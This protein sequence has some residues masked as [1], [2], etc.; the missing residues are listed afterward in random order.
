[1]R[2]RLR[3]IPAA[4]ALAMALS[5]RAAAQDAASSTATQATAV[6]ST[7][8]SE[9]VVGPAQ[10]RDFSLQGTV[11]RR[12]ET[13]APA[14]ATSPSPPE[15][16]SSGPEP[17]A[18]APAPA[19]RVEPGRQ[20][21]A[22]ATGTDPVGRTDSSRS[23]AGALPA[24]DQ[25]LSFSPATLAPQSI[26]ASE[27]A[28]TEGSTTDA[29]GGL[30]SYW[31]W[32]LAFLTALGAGLWYL[33]RQR[34]AHHYAYAG[35]GADAVAFERSP[36]PKPPAPPRAEPFT[37]APAPVPNPAP[38]P[39]LR[40]PEERALS[41]TIVSTKLRAAPEAKPAVAPPPAPL[42]I[43]STRLRP[44]LDIEF[45]PLEAAFNDRQGVIQFDVTLFNSGSGPAREVLLEARLF[46]AGADQDDSIARYFANPTVEGD[47]IGVIEPLKRMT[48]RTSAMVP[49]EQ[50]RIFEA[51]G[52]KVWVP[53]IGFNASY[54]WSGG[55]GQTS[56]SYL[57][58]RHT[59]GEK[60][61]PFR[62]DV[63]ARTFK[64]LGAREHTVRVRR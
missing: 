37:A 47:R 2:A 60:M 10:L 26:V 43:V 12:A 15:A 58:G 20:A 42:G 54:R 28:P 14:Q 19:A 38:A 5:A 24:A 16:G 48:F 52:R 13:P 46:N 29:R 36:L 57:L 35:A 27:P 45:E 11:T 56:A 8:P 9:E 53:L 18:A 41:G 62:V 22:A 61:A 31:A 17:S 7:P 30:V 55:D 32:L 33:R 51:G 21:T 23:K 63:G 49:R 3:V 39:P 25:S 4:V 50:M 6:P 44:W 1:M 40:V 34:T 59:N 64:G